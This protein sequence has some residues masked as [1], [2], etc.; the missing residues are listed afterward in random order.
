MALPISPQPVRGFTRVSPT[1]FLAGIVKV[2]SNV[3]LLKGFQPA[4]TLWERLTSF[5][6]RRP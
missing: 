2:R 4:P 6:F 3:W 1:T 5:P